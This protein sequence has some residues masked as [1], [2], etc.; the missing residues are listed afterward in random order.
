VL[1]SAVPDDVV[2]PAAAHYA[3]SPVTITG[4]CCVVHILTAAD[5]R[6][7]WNAALAGLAAIRFDRALSCRIGVGWP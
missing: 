3:E 4:L 7:P 1:R 6:P 5:L 2:C